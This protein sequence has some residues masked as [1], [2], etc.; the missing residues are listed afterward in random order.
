MA[1]ILNHVVMEG[2]GR[3]GVECGGRTHASHVGGKHTALTSIALIG[4]KFMKFM[5]VRG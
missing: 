1:V 3:G 5:I 4:G 2:V